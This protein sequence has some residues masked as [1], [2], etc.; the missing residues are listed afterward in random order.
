[1]V[2]PSKIREATMDMG[3]R[4]V[5]EM[6]IGDYWENCWTEEGKPE[7]FRSY[8]AAEQ[9]IKDHITDCINAVE[10]GEMDDSP[11]PTDFRIVAV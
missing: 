10:G 2:R 5:V 9:A 4:F 6:L 1:M 3:T 8:D 11:D 7:T